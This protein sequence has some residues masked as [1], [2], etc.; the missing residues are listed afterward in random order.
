MK[1]KKYLRLTASLVSVSVLAGATFVHLPFVYATPPITQGA[2]NQSQ[3]DN[4]STTYTWEGEGLD[5]PVI[6]SLSVK[7][8]DTV[9]EVPNPE[10]PS[11]NHDI[12]VAICPNVEAGRRSGLF[13][14]QKIDM[15]NDFDLTTAKSPVSD[16]ILDANSEI[17]I[18][19]EDFGDL[20]QYFSFALVHGD[21]TNYETS[22]LG[23]PEATMSITLKPVRTP[24]GSGD[25]VDND[26]SFCTAT[27]PNCNADHSQ[28]DAFSASLDMTFDQTGYGNEFT[29]SYFAMTGAMGAWVEPQGPEGQPRSIKASLGG[30]HFLADGTTL[31]IGSLQA[32]IPDAAVLNMFEV[33]SGELTSDSLSVTRTESGETAD[34]PFELEQVDGGI[35]VSMDNVHFSS[36]SYNIG[37]AGF[38]G[39]GGGGEEADNS[40]MLTLPGGMLVN[41]QTPDGT[42]ITSFTSASEE[43]LASQDAGYSY[44]LGLGNFSFTVPNGSTQRV[45]LAYLTDLK[46]NQVTVRKYNSVTNTFASIAGATLEEDQMDGHHVLIAGYDITDNGTLDQNATLGIITDPV[47]LGVL[48]VGT[49]NTGFA[50]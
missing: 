40:K 47:G 2:P 14:Y 18:T 46:P 35:L 19:I 15:A 39:S 29:G 12:G 34:A 3:C 44:P 38:N 8:G 13:V 21:V 36:P 10:V 17:T 23:T 28:V 27:P 33:S 48:A 16:T 1:I 24:F 32:F 37:L 45:Y 30:P 9:E 25:D 26:F 22:N 5:R 49:P 20:A 41:L 43:S 50:R 7:V 42:T 11:E 6:S 31:N 4:G